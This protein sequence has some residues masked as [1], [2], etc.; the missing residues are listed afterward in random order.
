MRSEVTYL[1]Y[2]KDNAQHRQWREGF[3]KAFTPYAHEHQSDEPY[4]FNGDIR[5]CMVYGEPVGILSYRVPRFMPNTYHISALMVLASHR[6]Q[7]LGTLLLCSFMAL[8]RRDDP[9][10]IF[11]LCVYQDNE[12]AAQFFGKLGFEKSIDSNTIRPFNVLMRK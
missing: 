10:A 12:P 1:V 9:T 2:D 4:D 7:G 11:R 3:A 5:F 8:I 6:Q